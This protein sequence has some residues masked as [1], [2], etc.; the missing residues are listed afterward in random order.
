MLVG[1]VVI[2]NK[3]CRMLRM[4]FGSPYILYFIYLTIRFIECFPV[5]FGLSLHSSGRAGGSYD[6]RRFIDP[7]FPRDNVYARNAFH[8]DTV[9]RDNYPSQHGG[10]PH[11][12]RSYEEEYSIDREPRR[13]DKSYV[14]SYQEMHSFVESDKYNEIDKYH[15]YDKLR[16]DYRDIDS[17]R[18]NGFER[19]ARYAGRDRE[20]Y[21]L[22][23]YD[24]RPRVSRQSR[25]DSRE[26][27]YDYGRYSYDSDYDRG[28][29]RDGKWRRH[30][31]RDRER[32]GLSRERDP[33]PYR[34]HDR[35]RSRGHDDRLRSRSPRGRSH[36][37]SYRED[38]YDDARYERSE[39]RRDHNEKRHHDHLEVV[40][41]ILNFMI[42]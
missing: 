40:C 42:R 34:R 29:R 26:R 18:D 31:S 12:R 33:S 27:D 21:A 5:I 2:E 39:K 25:Q 3:C 20:D 13:H 16:D 9:E 37:R 35:S 38:S 28:S 30:D 24:Y 15:D 4:I 41:L 6:D 1:P 22:D 19:S 17:F 10:W 23:D 36:S 11:S 14:D 8:R 7:R 32:S